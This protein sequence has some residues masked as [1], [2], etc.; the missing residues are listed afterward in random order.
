MK[1][2]EWQHIRYPNHKQ[3]RLR[4]PCGAKL[5][6]SVFIQ[7]IAVLRPNKVFAVQL[8][9]EALQRFFT[10][11]SFVE[12]LEEN[13][14]SWAVQDEGIL[15]DMYDGQVWKFFQEKDSFSTP[16]NSSLTMN[17][18]WFRPFKRTSYSVGVI[19]QEK[20]DSKRMLSLL[21]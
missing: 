13:L 18:D 4:A 20:F 16:L 19:Y 5:L 15:R 17:I 12:T 9:S 21:E 10:R 3:A 7:G 8:P 6:K 2:A 11:N 14:S 1:S